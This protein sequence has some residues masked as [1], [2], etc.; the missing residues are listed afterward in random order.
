MVWILPSRWTSI[1]IHSERALTTLMPTPC[2]PPETVYAFFSNLPPACRELDTTSRA[3]LP[4]ACLSV[5]M[6]L[7]SSWTQTDPSLQSVIL[8]FLQYPANASSIELST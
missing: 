7:P 6:P 3:D 8:I 1:L 5:G 2:S 4:D